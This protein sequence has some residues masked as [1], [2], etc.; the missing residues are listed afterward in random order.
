[1]VVASIV[2]ASL[3]FMPIHNPTGWIALAALLMFG[4]LGFIDDYKKV[5]SQSVKAS[6]GL[7][8]LTRLIVEG[9]FVVILAYLINKT[10]PPYIP[11]YSLAIGAGI[12][13]VKE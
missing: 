10:M 1:M 5:S 11:E 7:S 4:G 2:V 8:P 12:I 6:N 9:V 13:F 3:L